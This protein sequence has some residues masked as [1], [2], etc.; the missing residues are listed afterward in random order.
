MT[1]SWWRRGAAATALTVVA[2]FWGC[3]DGDA[4][5]GPRAP[6]GSTSPPAASSAVGSPAAGGDPPALPDTVPSPPAGP[7]RWTAGR[8]AVEREVSGAAVLREMR[9][10]GHEGFDRLV[11]HFDGEIPSYTAEYVDRPVRACGS[12]HVVEV[13]GDGWLSLTFTPARAHTEAGEATV[14][15]RDRRFDHAVVR[16]ATVTCD[17]EAHLVW[18][19]GVASPNRFR[20]FELADPARVVVDV[21]H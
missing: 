16:Q 5:E 8:V 3:G 10:A 18:V 9:V 20:V 17:F 4:A 1:G 2:S 11:F 7:D 19:V 13:A 12:G 15:D 14:N 6:E 21:R